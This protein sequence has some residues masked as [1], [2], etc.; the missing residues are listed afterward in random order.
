MFIQI[1][2]ASV[3]DPAA[4]H[5]AVDRWQAELKPGAQGYLGMTSGV[6]DDA[7]FIA[8]VRF[9]SAEAARANSERPEQDAWWRETSMLFDAE[10]RVYDCPTV[11]VLLDGGSDDAGF[12]QLEVFTG[13]KDIEA[14]RAIDKE[15]ARLGHL[16]PDLLGV[17]TAFTTDGQLFATNY[18]TSEAEA[19]AAEAQEWPAEVLALVERLTELTDGVEYIDLRTPWLHS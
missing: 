14:V 9:A 5:A 4:A 6:A 1:L 12:V 3:T 7:T 15:F 18:F 11:D 13:V 10:P 16:R 19:R 17:T 2:R 8:V